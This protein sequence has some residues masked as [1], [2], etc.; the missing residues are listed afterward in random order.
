M[1]IRAST[2]KYIEI[3]L[4]VC[5]YYIRSDFHERLQVNSVIIEGN[6][7]VQTLS[8]E[9]LTK[10]SSLLLEIAKDSGKGFANYISD[11]M[12]RCKIQRIGL[13]C[14]LS[15]VYAD[16]SDYQQINGTGVYSMVNLPNL[17]S[18]SKR[19]ISNRSLIDLQKTLLIFI[20]S[21]IHLEYLIGTE[22]ITQ[23]YNQKNHQTNS[24]PFEYIPF[25]PI[26]TQPMFISATLTVLSEKSWVHIHDNWISLV[27]SCL[28]KFS[29]SMTHLIIPVVKQICTNLVMLT[30]LVHRQYSDCCTEIP[31]DYMI[32]LLN[33]L[34]SISHF[35]LIGT[36]T[37]ALMVSAAMHPMSKLKAG[38][39]D[40]S[41]S[42]F[43]NLVHVFS[44]NPQAKQ[45]SEEGKCFKFF[46]FLMNFKKHF[47]LPF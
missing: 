47:S 11:L 23:P 20:E 28:P 26:I 10:I 12:S 30:D 25:K 3:L 42:L 27:I 1:L 29:E 45:S 16:S 8:A 40:I 19:N 37:Q 44:S 33:G 32:V 18:T 36:S 6:F 38:V 39:D 35:S 5:L 24:S 34:T 46:K 13:H 9:V 43:S 15:T 22:N 31:V 41:T 17:T 21:F 2:A 7:L 14:L 4:S